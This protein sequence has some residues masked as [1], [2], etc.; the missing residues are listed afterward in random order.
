MR[1]IIRFFDILF[2]SLGWIILSPLCIILAV[3][4]K[5]DSKGQVFTDNYGLGKMVKIFICI[6]SEQWWWMPIIMG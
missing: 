4:I 1:M 6:N 5:L 3:W 2:S